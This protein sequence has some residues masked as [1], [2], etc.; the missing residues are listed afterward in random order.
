MVGKHDKYQKIIFH[1][2]NIF[3]ILY[4][5]RLKTRLSSS[6]ETHRC[7]AMLD[8]INR[9]KFIF[10]LKWSWSELCKSDQTF[11]YRQYQTGCMT[12]SN[13]YISWCCWSVECQILISLKFYTAISQPF[14]GRGISDMTFTHCTHVGIEP[15]SSGWNRNTRTA[16]L[17]NCHLFKGMRVSKY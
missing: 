17:L 7:C 14:H 5:E 6:C 9:I 12:K 4:R 2:V 11:P 15:N 8:N 1:K 16:R 13:I 3:Y 10:M